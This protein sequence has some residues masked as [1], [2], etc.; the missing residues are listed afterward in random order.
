MNP[1]DPFGFLGDQFKQAIAQALL[2][3]C[4][5]LV[6]F[7][8]NFLVH[9][10]RPPEGD[11]TNWLY[12]NAIG[13][14]GYFA[15]S[16][17]ISGLLLAYFS[18]KIAIRAGYA[19]I[20]ALLATPLFVLFFEL[21]DGVTKAADSVTAAL[22]KSGDL[23][24]GGNLIVVPSIGDPIWALFGLGGIFVSGGALTLVMVIYAI[25]IIAVKFLTLIVLV[26]S[27][28]FEWAR[29]W[30]EWCISLG[31]V[32]ML[33]GR[34]VAMLI[35]LMVKGITYSVHSVAFG[36]IALVAGLAFATY[37]Q[38][39]LVKKTHSVVGKVAAHA[40]SRVSGRVETYNKPGTARNVLAVQQAHMRGMNPSY[41][42]LTRTQ[43]LGLAVRQH[44]HARSVA[45][46]AALATTTT[47][48]A[49]KTALIIYQRALKNR[50]PQPRGRRRP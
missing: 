11:W 45:R 41:Q 19:V 4:I 2:Q 12:G 29:R 28:F 33:L 32:A 44:Q 48:P 30:F 5:D 24:G 17:A 50:P 18:R 9:P 25:I 8:Q 34:T 20:I 14:S 43:A 21:C 23:M 39:K 47:N 16:L 31:L 35:I 46:V 37:L 40:R 38:Y 42:R 27:S 36:V 15:V 3:K 26:L 22:A 6:N 7:F 10:V 49:L 1:F 13:L